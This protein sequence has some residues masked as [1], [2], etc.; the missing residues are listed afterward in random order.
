MASSLVLQKLELHHV[1]PGQALPFDTFDAN[2]VLL[3][4]KGFVI[5]SQD[6]LER[7]VERGLFSDEVAFK[8]H[9]SPDARPSFQ[10]V[11]GVKVSVLQLLQDLQAELGQLLVAT[12]APT[13]FSAQVL[14]IARGVQR[15]C[16]LDSDAALA[17]I[18]RLH[19]GR[20]SVRRMVHAAI[21][22][23]LLLDSMGE[24][25]TQR[26]PALAAAL[27]MNIAMLDLQD[28][29]FLQRDPPSPIQKDQIQ[30]HPAQGAQRLR[31]LGVT[32]E[33]WLLTVLH[34]HETIDGQGYPGGLQADALG[35]PA[36]VLCMADRFGALC[37]GRAHRA[38]ALPSA[39]LKELFLDRGKGLDAA[40]VSLLVKVVGVYPPGSLVRLANADLA[41]VVKRTQSANHPIVRTV[42]TQRGERPNPPRKRTTS[43]PTYA[44]E[45]LVLPSV[46]DFEVD[47][48]TLWDE[49]FEVQ[50]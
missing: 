15:A 41:V 21:L 50:S 4:R 44:I 38:P 35:R 7:L 40:L 9:F 32:D 45:E 36:Q 30:A 16:R 3:L 23:E 43:D 14:E 29:L 46:L 37:T 34:H 10:P 47:P 26:L 2:G 48:Q 27:T 19:V 11:K 1:S 20:Y 39:A 42:R 12:P 31:D 25:D 13:D 5:Q 28:T 22:C 17:S 49:G 18:Q 24:S 6:Q 33:A 8:A